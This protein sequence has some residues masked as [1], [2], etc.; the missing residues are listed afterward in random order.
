MAC[1][2]LQKRIVAGQFDDIFDIAYEG[3]NDSSAITFSRG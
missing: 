3:N 1:L 2:I